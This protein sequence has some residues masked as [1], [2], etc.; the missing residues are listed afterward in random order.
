MQLLD[1]LAYNP[2]NKPSFE[3]SDKKAIMA[4]APWME[5]VQ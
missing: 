3:K 2:A 1:V 5:T 4:N